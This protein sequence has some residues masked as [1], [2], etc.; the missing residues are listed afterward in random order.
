M[1]KT[2]NLPFIAEFS[3]INSSKTWVNK[4]GFG[5]EMSLT[6]WAMYF[7]E[8]VFVIKPLENE[9]TYERSFTYVYAYI[10]V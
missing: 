3:D 2:I 5:K 10:S 7:M 6:T 4:V 1:W 8:Y 9:E